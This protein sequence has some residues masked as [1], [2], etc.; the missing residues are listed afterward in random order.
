[1]PV[2]GDPVVDLKLKAGLG[3]QAV[4]GHA[5]ELEIRLFA[6]TPFDGELQIL[7]YNGLSILPVYLEERKEQTLWL[8]VIPDQAGLIRVRLQSRVSNIQEHSLVFMLS[9]TTLTLISRATSGETKLGGYRRL[10]GTTPTIISTTSLPHTPQAYDSVDAVVAEASFLA[11]LSQNQYS[12]LGSYLSGCGI[13]LLSADMKSFLERLRGV[14]G[15]GGQ[16]VQVYDSLSR[17]S[18][19]LVELMSLRP[20]R[21]PSAHELVSLQHTGMQTA[22]MNAVALYLGGYLLFTALVTWRAKQLRQLML[23]PLLVAGAGI[24]A[25]SGTGSHRVIT[26][27]ESES[28]DGHIRV[29]SLLLLGGSRRGESRLRLLSDARLIS[30]AGASRSSGIVYQDRDGETV[31]HGHTDLLSPQTYLLTSVRRQSP[32]FQLTIQDGIPEI[33]FFGKRS[34][35]QTRLLWRGQ[36]Y[37][38]PSLTYEGRWRPDESQGHRPNN[39]EERLLNRRLAYGDPALLLPFTSGIPALNGPEVINAGWLVIRPASNILL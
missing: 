31:L 21:P 24:L 29:S 13:M 18:S 27:A 22:T 23:L 4:F 36:A 19:L 14:S 15:C 20:P 6:A 17:V 10:E 34:P 9:P 26:W 30:V 35:A 11:G 12:A 32:L 28:G 3:G 25:W 16:F 33:V 37:N 38:I 39:N 5:T 1:V 8:P 7:D 2:A